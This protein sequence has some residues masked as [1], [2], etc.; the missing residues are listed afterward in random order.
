MEFPILMSKAMLIGNKRG[1]KLS[2]LRTGT[3]LDAFYF[4][5]NRIFV[6]RILQSTA[7]YHSVYI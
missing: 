5:I 3:S 2:L 6:Q 1:G 7:K 4:S